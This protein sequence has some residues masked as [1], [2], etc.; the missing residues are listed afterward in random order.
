MNF[1]IK[2]LFCIIFS[3]FSLSFSAQRNVGIGTSSPMAKL[4]INEANNPF[5]SP[6]RVDFESTPKLVVGP[7]GGTTIGSE[8]GA[9][10]NGLYVKGNLGIGIL[11]SPDKLSIGG[12]MSITGEI[13]PNGN[14]GTPGQFLTPSSNGQMN[15]SD[16][17]QFK[18]VQGFSYNE[19]TQEWIVPEGVTYVEIEMWG[20]G[21]GGGN[22]KLSNQ[23]YGGTA[24]DQVYGGMA[25]GYVSMRLNV[26]PENVISITVGKGGFG[27]HSLS[28]SSPKEPGGDSNVTSVGL[29][30]S[31]YGGNSDIPTGGKFGGAVAI[32]SYWGANGMEGGVKEK[33]Q[34]SFTPGYI[35]HA[36]YVGAKGGLAYPYE[37]HKADGGRLYYAH[38]HS[39]PPTKGENGR[40]YGSGGGGAPATAAGDGASGYVKSKW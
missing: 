11:D 29:Y 12:D 25:G 13:K 39:E 26:I 20:G 34:S 35:P 6:F 24:P 40:L 37:G 38:Y 9:P 19:N 27:Y 31:A 1:P 4:H 17:P 8:F 10:T 28:T 30:I 22:V 18:H 32:G 33:Y 14:Q 16:F 21:E 15:W 3:F 36:T 5:K 2:M 7:N 23:I